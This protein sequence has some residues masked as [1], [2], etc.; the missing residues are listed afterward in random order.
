[1][2]ITVF[3]NASFPLSGETFLSSNIRLVPNVLSL[4]L[5]FPVN[6]Y[7][8]QIIMSGNMCTSEFYSLNQALFEIMCFYDFFGVVLSVFPNWYVREIQHFFLGF[9]LTARPCLL[10]LICVERYLAVV[11]PVAFLRMK[12]LKYRLA[13]LGIIWLWTLTTGVC[14]LVL[15]DFKENVVWQVAVCCAVN[16]Y[17]CVA[18]LHALRRPGPGEG[19]RQREGMS[20]VKLK[21][22]RIILIITVSVFVMYVPLVLVV[23]LKNYFTEEL[24]VDIL[25]MFFI[26]TAVSGF[27]QASLFLQRVGK[28]TFVK[29]P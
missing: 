19:L 27:I 15:T 29:W 23:L 11:K 10:A 16:L 26:C 24:F 17:C 22:F 7:V 2:N 14:V 8:L 12:S 18:T 13:M 1:M 28:L 25:N 3:E 4:I 6:I 20:N 21:A 9:V 5:R